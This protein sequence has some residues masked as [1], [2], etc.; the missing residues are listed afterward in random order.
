MV[1]KACC[2]RTLVFHGALRTRLV[3]F[4]TFCDKAI[5]GRSNAS[6]HKK[7]K[8]TDRIFCRAVHWQPCSRG[9]SVGSQTPVSSG[10]RL[11]C[12]SATTPSDDD[13]H[14]YQDHDCEDHG[15]EDEEAAVEADAANQ[16][17]AGMAAATGEITWALHAS[18][19]KSINPLGKI[20]NL[21][22]PIR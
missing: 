13:D 12:V 1:K 3:Q 6:P 19:L 15:D 14:H 7:K 4:E 9:Q 11:V 17:R 10:S 16:A 20:A 5:H 22:T 21:P 8:S 2:Q 18:T